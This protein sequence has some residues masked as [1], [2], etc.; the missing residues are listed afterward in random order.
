MDGTESDTQY[1]VRVFNNTFDTTVTTGSNSFYGP[2]SGWEVQVE[3]AV[4][5][6]T[7]FIRLETVQGTQISPR[8][9]VTFTGN[10]AQNAAL[11]D[12]VRTR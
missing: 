2:L 12:F 6:N 1:R 3:N 11:V 5:T 7:Y 4:S 8:I 10:C 9:E